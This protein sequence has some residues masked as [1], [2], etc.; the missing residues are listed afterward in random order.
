MSLFSLCK[1]MTSALRIMM[2]LLVGGCP[3]RS[4]YGMHQISMHRKVHCVSG[5]RGSVSQ[6]CAA[7]AYIIMT[8][9]T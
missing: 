7:S 1:S 6:V 9:A 8:A 4:I 2:A 3:L 5:L